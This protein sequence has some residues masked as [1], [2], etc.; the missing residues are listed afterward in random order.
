MKARVWFALILIALLLVAVPLSQAWAGGRAGGGGG[1]G[2]GGHGGHGH[3]HGRVFIGTGFWWPGPYYYPYYYPYAYPY[4]YAYQ[5][6]PVIVEQPVYTQRA[7]PAPESYWYYCQSAQGYYPTV[8]SCQE[9]WIK[10]PP[11]SE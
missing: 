9:A 6:A 11:R 8:S 4:P 3:F 2:H 5:P 7:E 10:V 1:W